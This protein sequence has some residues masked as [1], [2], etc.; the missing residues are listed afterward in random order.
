M[1]GE[2]H[3]NEANMKVIYEADD[4]TRFT[5]ALDCEDYEWKL[6]HPWNK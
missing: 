4:G 5:N 2:N 6:K 1:I 3:R